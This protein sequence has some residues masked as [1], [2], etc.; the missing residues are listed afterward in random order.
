[1]DLVGDRLVLP[2]IDAQLV[3]SKMY[4][5]CDGVSLIALSPQYKERLRSHPDLIARYET[6]V[7]AMSCAVVVQPTLIGGLATTNWAATLELAVFSAMAVRLATGVPVDVPFWFDVEGEKIRGFGNTHVRTFRIE[8]RYLYP[9]DDGQQL[10]GIAAL[11]R[12]FDDVLKK[13][14]NDANSNVLIRAIHFAAIAF[15]TR[16]IPSRLVN[17]TI[18]V[19]ALFSGNTT[20]IAFQIASC[21]SWYLEATNSGEK[22]VELFSKMKEIYSYR[23][24]IVHGADVSSKNKNL[25]QALASSEVINTRIFQKVL[26]E[27]HVEIF[28]MRKDKR[29]Q[30]LKLLSL[31]AGSTL[32]DKRA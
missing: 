14:V 24:K 15:Q 10:D 9:L 25:R 11:Q 28:S 22:R 21:V 18:Y 13:Y 1:M 6:S 12:G 26:N 30:E 19:E 20:E 23:S 17:N 16:H 8:N 2:L 4:Q 27:K 32:I 29:D 3:H 5:L 7:D 31:G